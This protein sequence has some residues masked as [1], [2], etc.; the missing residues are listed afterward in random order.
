MGAEGDPLDAFAQEME[1]LFESGATRT[2]VG[3]RQF[4]P[5]AT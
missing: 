5:R 1:D 3:G 4:I 2:T